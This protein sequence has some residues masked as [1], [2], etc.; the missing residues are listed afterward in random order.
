[1]TPAQ[2]TVLIR[3]LQHKGWL[4]FVQCLDLTGATNSA[5]DHAMLGAIIRE[6]VADDVLAYRDD[7]CNGSTV[8]MFMVPIF[9]EI[10][11]V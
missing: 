9:R 3:S 4:S 2:R 7:V 11:K 6:A 8:P 1:M 10:N 5:Q